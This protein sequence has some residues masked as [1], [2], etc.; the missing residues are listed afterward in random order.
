MRNLQ[1]ELQRSP[2]EGRRKETMKYEEMLP[3]VSKSPRQGVSGT[4]VDFDQLVV[5]E[6]ERDVQ[7]R[8]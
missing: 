8:I 6:V 7:R 5:G 2:A 4:E 1:G 3:S